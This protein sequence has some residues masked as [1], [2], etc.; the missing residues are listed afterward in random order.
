M[1]N[2]NPPPFPDPPPHPDQP[3][4][5]NPPPTADALVGKTLGDYRVLQKL[6]RG[7]MAEVYLAEQVSLERKVALK[8]LEADV[9]KEKSDIERFLREARAAARL[10]HANIVQVYEVGQIG[11]IHYIAQEYVDGENLGQL[12]ARVGQLDAASFVQILGQVAS[13]LTCAGDAGIV[14]RDIKPENL[15][16]TPVGEVKVADF[17][18]ARV[19]EGGHQPRL[20]EDG[21]TMGSPLYMSPEQIEG[22]TLDKRSDIY[23]L[24][25]TCFQILA[26][27]PPFEANTSMNVALQHLR[28]LPPPLQTIRSDLPKKL[29]QIVDRMLAKDPQD[30]FSDGQ[31]VLQALD[32]FSPGSTNRGFPLPIA[33]TRHA[34]SEGLI[35][36]R[37]AA[38]QQLSA[39]MA[40][41][42]AFRPLGKTPLFWASIGGALLLGVT[43]GLPER[44]PFLLAG[45]D[46][47]QTEIRNMGGVEAQYELARR[48]GTEEGWESVSLYFPADRQYR[49]RAEKELA[50]LYLQQDRRN[51]ALEVF[52]QFVSQNPTD[53]EF[54]AYGLA[55]QYVIMVLDG[56]QESAFQIFERL[57]PLRQKLSSFAPET[58]R[59]VLMHAR[60]HNPK[61]TPPMRVEMTR[62]LKKNRPVQE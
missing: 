51:E 40:R 43:L 6:G 57:W 17:G 35:E 19:F 32:Q 50:E 20:T 49:S 26:G 46:D 3:S 55:G 8:I 16:L 60:E 52:G 47:L 53:S 44:D 14:H 29:C 56:E 4:E 33:P 18:L 30:R 25:V 45:A 10:V 59:R 41:E 42:Q 31:A 48:L 38:T 5:S 24:G 61:I 13:A 22:K 34:A 9:A 28:D 21:M 62:W 23:S 54:H 2:G 7:A 1:T 15:L 11:S 27:R 39:V 12:I 36:N 37:H 58:T